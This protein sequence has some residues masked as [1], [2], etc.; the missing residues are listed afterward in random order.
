MDRHTISSHMMVWYI[1]DM[2]GTSHLMTEFSQ[3]HRFCDDNEDHHQWLQRKVD[4]LGTYH[5]LGVSDSS[6]T[7]QDGNISFSKIVCRKGSHSICLLD[8]FSA[9]HYR[10]ALNIQEHYL[11]Q[12]VYIYHNIG[13]F[14]QSEVFAYRC[15][16]LE[17]I[18]HLQST[19]NKMG[20][21]HRSHLV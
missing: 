8:G 13:S 16:S 19:R 1:Q 21:C 12:P 9:N 4:N 6:C 20:I 3:M 10:L 15:T 17:H 2:S 11:G 5:F 14:H 18:Y 7:S